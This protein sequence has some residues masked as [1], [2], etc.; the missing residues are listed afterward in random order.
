MKKICFLH[1]PA[2]INGN[3]SGRKPKYIILD[4]QSCEVAVYEG[5]GELPP[6]IGPLSRE[7]LSELLQLSYVIPPNTVY[8]DVYTVNIGDSLI[9]SREN[10]SVRITYDHKFPFLERFREKKSLCQSDFLEALYC[11]AQRQVAGKEPLL[12]H[13][14]G[15]DSNTIL[16]SYLEAG[17]AS[18]LTLLSGA[19]SG[20]SDESEI[21]KSIAKKFGLRY[22]SIPI[23]EKLDDA[24]L[25]YLKAQLALHAFPNLDAVMLPLCLYGYTG[26]DFEGRDCIFGDGNDG[27]FLSLPSRLESRLS[28]LTGLLSRFRKIKLP[29]SS[30]SKLGG[31]LRSKMEWSGVY[32]LSYY[33]T[34]KLLNGAINAFDRIVLDEGFRDGLNPLEFKSDAYATRAISQRM[35]QKLA[36]FCCANDAN[37]VLPFADE[38]FVSAWGY[39]EAGR[40]ANEGGGLN[41]VLLRNIVLDVVGIDTTAVGKKGWSFDYVKFVQEHRELILREVARCSYWKP[42]ISEWINQM[43]QARD[44]LTTSKIHACRSVYVVFMV[45]LWLCARYS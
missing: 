32:G 31:L 3:L 29:V 25:D 34:D 35:I 26:F 41:K 38:E 20:K 23:L 27:Y 1:K 28:P 36:L 12:F 39:L 9:F 44:S 14:A 7:N 8:E 18:S 42:A 30:S 43:C 2:R 21:S 13:T 19:S 5:E 24:K 6:H 16:A 33:D 22:V 10:G 15:K 45:S 11:A 17:R 4:R 40:V 37:C